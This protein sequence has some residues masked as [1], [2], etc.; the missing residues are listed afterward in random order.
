MK[1]IKGYLNS[2][3]LDLEH[4]LRKARLR[5]KYRKISINKIFIGEGE[6]KHTNDKVNITLYVYN[7][8]KLNYLLKLKKK[9]IRVFRKS[10]FTRKLKLIKN[11]G[12]NILNKQK[13]KSLI[14]ANVIPKYNSKINKEV[15]NHSS[16]KL[17]PFI[18]WTL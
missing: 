9:Y 18:T 5:R 2:Y 12:L 4:L 8:Q 1:L 15:S 17:A 13:N 7:R 6:F 16:M 11:V 3:N 10:I 14:L